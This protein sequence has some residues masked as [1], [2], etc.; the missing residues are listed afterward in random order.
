MVGGGALT[1]Y[2]FMSLLQLH[3]LIYIMPSDKQLKCLPH[4]VKL[5]LVCPVEN[6]LT[7]LLTGKLV[8]VTFGVFVTLEP[9]PPVTKYTLYFRVKFHFLNLKTNSRS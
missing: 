1:S 2:F 3:S 4:Q 7:E 9:A 8:C 5:K 6:N